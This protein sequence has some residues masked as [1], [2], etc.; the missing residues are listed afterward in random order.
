MFL[1]E[2]TEELL[3][4][5]LWMRTAYRVQVPF[6]KHIIGILLDQV[7]V[8]TSRDFGPAQT[9]EEAEPLPGVGDETHPRIPE[10]DHVMA[11]RL[12]V[13]RTVSFRPPR[14]H[15]KRPANRSGL[16]W[17]A[18]GFSAPCAFSGI[19]CRIYNRK[20]THEGY[21]TQ[22]RTLD[23]AFLDGVLPVNS[24]SQEV[25]EKVIPLPK[26]VVPGAGIPCHRMTPVSGDPQPSTFDSVILF[27]SDRPG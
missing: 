20:R 26:E 11:L 14:R 1:P 3:Q 12:P 17:A 13:H 6:P 25:A 4:V 22:R 18:P 16:C 15:R 2:A 23:Q 9:T 19:A 27:G 7:R 10:I 8:R 24:M 5:Q 21:R